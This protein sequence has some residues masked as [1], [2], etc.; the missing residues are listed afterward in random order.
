[1]IKI[2]N[3]VDTHDSNG[4]VLLE[5][6]KVRG[7]L[8]PRGPLR[9][10]PCQL[11]RGSPEMSPNGPQIALG[12]RPKSV[13]SCLWAR[14]RGLPGARLRPEAGALVKLCWRNLKIIS[15]RFWPWGG[16]IRAQALL[17][18]PDMRLKHIFSLRSMQVSIY[19]YAGALSWP[20]NSQTQQ[21]R[22]IY[23]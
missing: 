13:N 2:M 11:Q 19:R 21:F 10:Q 1:M 6:A 8:A 23:E 16:Q 4:N 15:G 14:R 9:S 17:P 18:A 20:G 7:I 3:K 5:E 22:G 12:A